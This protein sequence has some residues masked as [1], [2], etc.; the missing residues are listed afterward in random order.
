MS[1][2]TKNPN[3][4]WKWNGDDL[5]QFESPILYGGATA[6]TASVIDE[7][8]G[9]GTKVIRLGFP[10]GTINGA[11][12]FIPIKTVVPHQSLKISMTTYPDSGSNNT[13][14]T[15]SNKLSAGLNFCSDITKG[16]TIAMFQTFDLIGDDA[17]GVAVGNGFVGTGSLVMNLSC[18]ATYARVTKFEFN[19]YVA[20]TTGV[21]YPV[22]V[23]V[24]NSSGF[25]TTSSV[26]AACTINSI[27]PTF[28]ASWVNTQRN[29]IG[30]Y[31]QANSALTSG[32]SILMSDMSFAFI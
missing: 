9:T 14:L 27:Y 17:V 18:P 32:S 1:Y 10:S 8:Y 28:S 16:H 29:R 13:G 4:I 24:L 23:G 5:I 21:L 15:A 30:I 6:V 22:L 26:A 12:A 31:V 25:P 3:L 19:G 7:P 20:A 2:F 11:G